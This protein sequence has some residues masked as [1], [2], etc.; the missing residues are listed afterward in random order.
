MLA[1]VLG[2]AQVVDEVAGARDRAEGDECDEGIDDLRA[3]L[4]LL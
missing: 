4:Q 1:V 2:V 3:L